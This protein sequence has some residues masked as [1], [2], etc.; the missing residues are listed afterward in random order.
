MP[1]HSEESPDVSVHSQKAPISLRYG[2]F[3]A[4]GIGSP[5]ADVRVGLTLLESLVKA[6]V[7]RHER[8]MKCFDPRRARDAL[9]ALKAQVRSPAFRAGRA[10]PEAVPRD[11]SRRWRNP[12]V[13]T[14]FAQVSAP[15][16]AKFESP[17][18]FT[19]LKPPASP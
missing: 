8:A 1:T 4:E 16:S 19:V 10:S 17:E 6:L 9:P 14:E 3:Q 13:P 18:S 12:P 2:Q 15:A 5:P 11:P 7:K